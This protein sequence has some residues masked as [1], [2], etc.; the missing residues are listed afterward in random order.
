[1]SR[2]S[3]S[4]SNSQGTHVYGKFYSFYEEP[5]GQAYIEDWFDH[6]PEPW[7]IDCH[8]FD[9][10]YKNIKNVEVYFADQVFN[11]WLIKISCENARR[12]EF[13]SRLFYKTT[14]QMNIT[15]ILIGKKLFLFQDQRL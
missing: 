15:Q 11:T 12:A 7:N 4:D 5:S 14:C 8:S 1:M 10:N 2:K 13:L 9:V 3:K 6:H